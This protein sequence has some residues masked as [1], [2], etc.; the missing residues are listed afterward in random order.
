MSWD[1]RLEG[2]GDVESHTEGGTIALGG[3][4]EAIL[5]VTY[6]YSEVTKLVNFKFADLDGLKASETIP[7]LMRVVEVLGDRPNRD[8]WAPTPGNAGHAA[9]VLLKWAKQYPD[10]IWRVS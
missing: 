8:Y 4:T 10:G 1:I 5:N 3:S 9:T 2:A 6:N 7:T